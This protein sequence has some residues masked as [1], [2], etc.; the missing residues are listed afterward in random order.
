[1]KQLIDLTKDFKSSRPIF[2]LTKEEYGSRI[3]AELFEKYEP[4]PEEGNVLSELVCSHYNESFDSVGRQ[5]VVNTE[6]IAHKAMSTI[7]HSMNKFLE[8]NLEMRNPRQSKAYRWYYRNLPNNSEFNDVM[9]M[10]YK[11]MRSFC[12]EDMKASNV[13]HI[14]NAIALL[15]AIM[16][17]Y[18]QE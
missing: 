7:R 4:T 3:S 11:Y 5:F 12:N 14:N 13:E 2:R 16:E 17:K 18:E 1:M 9:I 15:E 8:K 10:M 6:D